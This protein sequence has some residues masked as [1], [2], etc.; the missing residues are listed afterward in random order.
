[1]QNYFIA[2]L[3]SVILLPS[4]LLRYLQNLSSATIFL[5]TIEGDAV[6]SAPSK[7]IVVNLNQIVIAVHGWRIWQVG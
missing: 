7:V 5:D 4:L 6:T 3:L 2:F 1:M